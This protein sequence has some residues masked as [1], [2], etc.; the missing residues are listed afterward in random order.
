MRS[1]ALAASANPMF[2]FARH[3]SCVMS[4][5]EPITNPAQTIKGPLGRLGLGTTSDRKGLKSRIKPNSKSQRPDAHWPRSKIGSIG[6]DRHIVQPNFCE[7]EESSIQAKPTTYA[8]GPN[9][10]G[11]F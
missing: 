5:A 6:L 2:R 7:I 8:T 9:K 11:R 3:H 4:R 10:L 1:A